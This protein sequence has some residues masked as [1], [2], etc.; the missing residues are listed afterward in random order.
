MSRVLSGNKR[1]RKR[2]HRL[3]GFRV[4]NIVGLGIATACL[5]ATVGFVLLEAR[6]YVVR[7]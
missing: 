4:L 7:R 1:N 3:P 6:D 2:P 5:L